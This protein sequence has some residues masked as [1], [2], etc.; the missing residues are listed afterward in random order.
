MFP[1]INQLV[2]HLSRPRPNSVHI[3]AATAARSLG[4]PLSMTSYTETA[5]ANSKK[6]IHTAACLIIGDEVL[7]G[8]TVDTNSPFFAKYCFSMGVSL[9]RIEVIA[10][11]ESEIIEAVK[12]MSEKYDFVVT[13]GGIGPT[14][15]S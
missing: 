5:L 9:K 3:P 1:R 7:G 15:V 4:S 13:S 6:T 14:F 12:R 11:D 2:R 8:K 10:D